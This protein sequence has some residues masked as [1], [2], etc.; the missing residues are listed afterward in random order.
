M[1][2]LSVQEARIK[3]KS[4]TELITEISQLIDE[5]RFR[6]KRTANAKAYS[7]YMG[8]LIPLYGILLKAVSGEAIGSEDTE[9]ITKA[10]AELIQRKPRRVY[11]IELRNGVVKHAG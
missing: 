11:K 6:A 1:S 7:R 4:K 5:I 3:G 8:T 10:I 9:E 2:E